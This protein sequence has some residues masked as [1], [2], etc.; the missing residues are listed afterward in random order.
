MAIDYDQFIR[1]TQVVLFQPTQ[2]PTMEVIELFLKNRNH[3]VF[4][5]VDL[6]KV[7]LHLLKKCAIFSPPSIQFDKNEPLRVKYDNTAKQFTIMITAAN[8]SFRD[9]KYVCLKINDKCVIINLFFD[10]TDPEKCRNDILQRVR[11]DLS[12]Q[13][14][15]CFDDST[16]VVVNHGGDYSVV[17]TLVP[18]TTKVRISSPMF[19]DFV[20]MKLYRCVKFSLDM[21][22]IHQLYISLFMVMD[23]PQINKVIAKLIKIDDVRKFVDCC[24]RLSNGEWIFYSRL[25]GEIEKADVVTD[26][27]SDGTSDYWKTLGIPVGSSKKMVRA[28]Y[29]RL[30]RKY[31]PDRRPKR[32]TETPEQKVDKDAKFLRIKEA[33]DALMKKTPNDKPDK[34]GPTVNEASINKWLSEKMILPVDK[35]R[36]FIHVAVTNHHTGCDAQRIADAIIG[37]LV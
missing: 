2:L 31:H 7:V 13:S 23:I 22:D 21:V 35:I 14:G 18:S 28:A 1:E 5:T 24:K 3:S 37:E 9:S 16:A 17:V 26:D 11:R 20:G 8:V 4:K 32:D 30:A 25:K 10:S 19:T 29:Y 27:I 36:A 12:E 33:Y 34:N 6:D 15:F